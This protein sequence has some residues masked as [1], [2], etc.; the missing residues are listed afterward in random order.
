MDFKSFKATRQQSSVHTDQEDL[1]KTAESYRG[2]SDE[3]ILSEILKMANQGKANG[4]FSEEQL[5]KFTQSVSP[6]LTE[7]QKKRL[8][9]VSELLKKS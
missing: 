6:M 4:T 7:E 5:Q 1:K 9:A 3:E 8:D 2:K